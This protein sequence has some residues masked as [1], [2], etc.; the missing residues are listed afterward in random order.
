MYTV[1]SFLSRALDR[2][3]AACRSYTD[4][5][6]SRKFPETFETCRGDFFYLRMNIFLN[7]QES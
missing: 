7:I 1:Q 6:F 4:F 3:A 5:Q 2:R